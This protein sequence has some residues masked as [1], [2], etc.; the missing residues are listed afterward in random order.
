MAHTG[1]EGACNKRCIFFNVRYFY[2]CDITFR[3]TLVTGQYITK[4]VPSLWKKFSPKLN[5]HMCCLELDFEEYA[6][7]LGS[8]LFY[9][10]IFAIYYH[11]KMKKKMRTI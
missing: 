9:N 5:F 6:V 10:I 4:T 2:G 1:Q 8:S 7:P 11:M 3:S